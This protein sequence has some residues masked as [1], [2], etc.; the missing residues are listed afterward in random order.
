[1]YLVIHWPMVGLKIELMDC[2]Y[3]LG[4]HLGSSMVCTM[5]MDSEKADVMDVC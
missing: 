5:T 2:C 3:L 1:M 4:S